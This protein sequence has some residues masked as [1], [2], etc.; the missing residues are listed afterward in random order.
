MAL[1]ITKISK[2]YDNN[3]LVK[4]IGQTELFNI[5]KKFIPRHALMNWYDSEKYPRTVKLI[6]NWRGQGAIEEKD[7]IAYRDLDYNKRRMNYRFGN[8]NQGIP[9][10]QVFSPYTFKTKNRYVP[11]AIPKEVADKAMEQFKEYAL[12]DVA[13]EDKWYHSIFKG[14]FK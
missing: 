13:I 6:I 11:P 8:I 3:V 9:K 7:I 4:T 12:K 2:V 1:F 5:N 10:G 14:K